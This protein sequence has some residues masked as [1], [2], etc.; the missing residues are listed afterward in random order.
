MAKANKT[1]ELTVAELEQMLSDRRKG[2]TRLHKKRAKLQE[3]I[4]A[5]DAEIRALG[6]TGATT[7]ARVRNEHSLG[8][9]VATVLTK[10]GEGLKVGEI[11]T[12]V[13]ATGYRTDSENF[14]SIVNQALIKDKRFTAIQRGI[15]GLKK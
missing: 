3:Q 7:G 10:A 5:M 9:V 8:E 1:P 15:Y 14:R 4:T 6:G 12:R 11:I 13:L 2:I